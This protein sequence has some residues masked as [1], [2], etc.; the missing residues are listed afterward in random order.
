MRVLFAGPFI[1]AER[2]MVSELK[3]NYI[4][5]APYLNIQRH[6]T[7]ITQLQQLFSGWISALVIEGLRC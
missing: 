7:S 1:A 3:N 2:D 6:F 5:Q 4:F